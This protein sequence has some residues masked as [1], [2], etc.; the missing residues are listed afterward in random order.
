MAGGVPADKALR[1]PA[2]AVWEAVEPLLPGFS[3]EILPTLPS[4]NTELME[5]AR[6]GRL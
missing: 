4:T 6:A 2:E 1:W 5:R 3:V